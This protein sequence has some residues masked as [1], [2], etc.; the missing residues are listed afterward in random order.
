MAKE[1]RLD[2]RIYLYELFPRW[3]EFKD[4]HVLKTDA[5]VARKYCYI[6]STLQKPQKRQNRLCGK[7]LIN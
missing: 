1:G 6:P 4:K 2:S 7:N 5:D 3:R